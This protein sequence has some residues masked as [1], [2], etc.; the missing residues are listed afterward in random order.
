VS[1]TGFRADNDALT[2]L[3]LRRNPLAVAGLAKHVATRFPSQFSARKENDIGLATHTTVPGRRAGGARWEH[4]G[5]G[6]RSLLLCFSL[7]RQIRRSASKS[8]K[9]LKVFKR[10]RHRDEIESFN[11]FK[12]V[13]KYFN[14]FDNFFLKKFKK[15]TNHIILHIF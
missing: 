2:I 14:F 3:D 15:F 9:L 4:T 1:A 7:R 6:G 8:H 13:Y 5:R 11:I 12:Y 10:E